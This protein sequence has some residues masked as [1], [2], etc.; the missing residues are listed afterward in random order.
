VRAAGVARQ[1]RPLVERARDL[2]ELSGLT[3]RQ[4]EVLDQVLAGRRVPQVARDL[5]LG[6]STVRSHLGVVF[7][8]LGV[9]S[10]D[11]LVERLRAS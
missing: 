6:Q 11:D 3:H 1:D 7:R 4:W 5:G 9:H 10:Q 8:R 2:P